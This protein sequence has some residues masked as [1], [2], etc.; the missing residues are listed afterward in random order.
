MKS[1]SGED[2]LNEIITK[3]DLWHNLFDS[4]KSKLDACEEY[5]NYLTNTYFAK[6]ARYPAQTW[7]YFDPNNERRE[8]T[9]NNNSE[10]VKNCQFSVH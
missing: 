1:N 6:N 8:A 2:D 5:L 10:R 3:F 9:T 4:F 7:C